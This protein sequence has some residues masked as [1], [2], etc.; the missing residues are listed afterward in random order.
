[1]PTYSLSQSSAGSTLDWGDMVVRF[2]AS[3][4]VG[5]SVSGTSGSTISITTTGA[6]SAIVCFVLDWNGVSG[7]SRTWTTVNS[8]TP[9][10]GNGY[11][12]DYTLVTS[13]YTSYVAYYPDAGAIGAKTVGLTAPTGMAPTILAVEI[14]G[15]VTQTGSGSLALSALQ[16]SGSNIPQTGS[17]SLALGRLAFSGSNSFHGIPPVIP[18]E[19]AGVISASSDLNAWGYACNFLLGNTTGTNPVFFL[20]AATT[21]TIATSFTQINFS[22]SGAIFKDNMGGWS[23]G[24]P[25]AY[26]IQ[27][28]GYYHIEWSMSAASGAGN[29]ECY[30]LAATSSS[31]PYNPSALIAFQHTNRQATSAVTVASAG[32]L[33]P[34]YLTAGDE[35]ALFAAVGTSVSTSSSFY[36][37][38]SGQWVSE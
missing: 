20:Q 24:N 19:N 1:M 35:I 34:I 22:N 7:A 29:L 33:V 36:P 12:L 15:T 11:E 5:A 32:G 30:A 4:G 21:Q 10:A 13:N 14:L 25:G 2:S 3:N 18:T 31:N 9:S 23:G 26:V 8:I 37:Q 38:L 16:F 17:G 6:N 27:A 28:P